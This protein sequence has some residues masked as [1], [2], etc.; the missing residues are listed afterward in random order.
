[1]IAATTDTVIVPDDIDT[2]QLAM[3]GIN[4][5]LEPA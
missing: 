5:M 1:V 4:P 3:V 2:V